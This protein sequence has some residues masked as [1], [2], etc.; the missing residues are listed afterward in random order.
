M[1]QDKKQFKAALDDYWRKVQ[2]IYAPM[3]IRT[4]IKTE[5]LCYTMSSRRTFTTTPT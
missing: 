1:Q 2:E 4:S 3:R 5:I